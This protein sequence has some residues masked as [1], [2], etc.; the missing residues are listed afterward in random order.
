ME[1]AWIESG[2]VHATTF[3]AKADEAF[4][5]VEP[6]E[7]E[8]EEL[9]EEEIEEQW[10]GDCY[11][12]ALTVGLPGTG[13]RDGL[14]WELVREE[15]VELHEGQR[16][17]YCDYGDNEWSSTSN[18]YYQYNFETFEDAHTYADAEQEVGCGIVY[19]MDATKSGKP[20]IQDCDDGELLRRYAF[21]NEWFEGPVLKGG[22]VTFDGDSWS[23]LEGL[24]GSLRE[25]F[26]AGDQLIVCTDEGFG[27]WD[28]V[29][30]TRTWW[31]DTPTC[32]VQSGE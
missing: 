7:E 29:A 15:T 30:G 20:C 11:T 25:F 9:T 17:P 16:R 24:E 14:L 8:F 2:Q 32:P 13:D 18:G 27:A 3:G 28:H 23:S 5:E 26:L 19:E 31:K 1:M 10:V 12:Y 4:V 22:V 6:G 21:G